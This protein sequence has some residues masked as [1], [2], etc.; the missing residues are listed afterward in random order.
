MFAVIEDNPTGSKTIT[1]CNAVKNTGAYLECFDIQYRSIVRY[2]DGDKAT[3]LLTNT[4]VRPKEWNLGILNN[5]RATLIKD[6]NKVAVLKKLLIESNRTFKN[7]LI[8]LNT[9]GNEKQK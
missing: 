6:K 3:N 9:Y 8:H 1:I 7:F 5:E 2:Q 4:K